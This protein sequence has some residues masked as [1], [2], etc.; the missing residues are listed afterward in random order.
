MSA[1]T[2]YVRSRDAHIAFQ[3]EGEGPLDIL[4]LSNGLNISIDETSDE[5]HWER[6][7]RRL[8]SFSRLIRFDMRGVG[9]SDPLS[10]SEDPTLDSVVQD[11]LAVLDG[12]EAGRVAVLG[13]GL[14]GALGILL[15]AT[16]PQRVSALVLVNTTARWLRGDDYPYG[17][18]AD[19]VAEWTE[20]ITDTTEAADVPEELSDAV[21][22]ASS[23]ASDPTFREWW[24]RAS[25]RGASPAAARVLA[26]MQM[27][28]DVRA[29]LSSI[30]VPS[31]VVHRSEQF[32][33]PIGH[34]QYLA[35]HVPG[36]QLVILPGSDTL[37]FSG[38]VDELIDPIEEF[39]T[40]GHQAREIDRVLATIMF[41]DIV[42]STEQ[43]AMLGDHRWHQV[44]AHHDAMVI[45]QVERFR[46]R[47]VKRIGDG[48]LMTF[49]GPAR[50]IS[51]AT[52]LVAGAQQL[53]IRLR[54]GLHSGEI[55]LLGDD[56]GGIAVNIASRVADLAGPDEIFVSRT[57]N[58]LVAGSAIAF[59]ERGEHELK[60]VPGAWKLFAVKA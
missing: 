24:S 48:A 33:L 42:G 26:R 34:A 6:Y 5:P 41:I 15:S 58:D 17:F 59:D 56:I 12:V 44:L 23:L 28:L 3:T 2:R 54:V 32:L 19:V 9:L 30:S 60:G 8:S 18:P 38:N 43:L 57:V 53:G 25:R 20:A 52:A 16:H 10:S 46:G 45:R 36:A 39:L 55:E 21:L 40:G 22:Y 13:S 47:L 35:D 49:D 27:N 7:V 31:M 1:P 51:C 50:A 11:A 14:G 29:I 4:E 37:P